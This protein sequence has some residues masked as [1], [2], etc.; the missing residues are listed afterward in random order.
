MNEEEFIKKLMEFI[1]QV[2]KRVDIIESEV[3]ALRDWLHTLQFF[4]DLRVERKVKNS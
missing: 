1:D 4:I 3:N 2:S